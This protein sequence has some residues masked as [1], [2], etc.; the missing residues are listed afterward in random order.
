LRHQHSALSF[1]SKRALFA[2]YAAAVLVTSRQAEC[3]A[4]RE[5]GWCLDIDQQPD[6]KVR[7]S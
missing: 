7:A 3:V 2:D 4:L 5:P 1:V 6:M